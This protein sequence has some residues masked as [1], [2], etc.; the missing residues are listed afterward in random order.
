MLQKLNIGPLP[1]IYTSD[2]KEVYQQ[3]LTPLDGHHLDGLFFLGLEFVQTNMW[4]ETY[5]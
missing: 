2:Q 3:M 1:W 5:P 4:S